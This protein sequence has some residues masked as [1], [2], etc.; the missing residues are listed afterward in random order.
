MFENVNGILLAGLFA[1]GGICGI[2]LIVKI[3]SLRRI[4]P[5]DMVHV[6]QTSKDTTSY[7]KN[8]KN[9]NVYYEW[10]KW[11]PILGVRVKDLPVSNFDMQLDN[12]EA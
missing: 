1:A 5:A 7:G 12:Y 2:I 10:P 11:L 6:V 9:G 4:V 8:S 3:L